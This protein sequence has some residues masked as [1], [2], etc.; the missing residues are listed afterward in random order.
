L[1]AYF[2]CFSYEE[3]EEDNS[4]L[5]TYVLGSPTYYEEVM[6]DTDQEQKY[7]DGYPNEDDEEQIFSMVHVCSDCETDPGE[8]HEGEKEESHLS[9]ILAHSF[10]PFNFSAIFGYPH[11]V[12]AINKWDD[13]LHRFRGSKP[14]HP[15]E[16]L[17][18]FH[19]CMLEHGFFHEDV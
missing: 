3:N 6:S 14:N 15:G 10:V 4:V 5:E 7:F 19:V 13:Y 18:K 1:K 8:R 9:A 12:S 11:P 16:H 2:S 17:L